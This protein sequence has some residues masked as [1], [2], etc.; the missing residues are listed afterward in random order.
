MQSRQEISQHREEGKTSKNQRTRMTYMKFL[1][2]QS[3]V[4][5]GKS[6]AIL[7][8]FMHCLTGSYKKDPDFSGPRLDCIVMFYF[9]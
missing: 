6:P 1:F 9:L 7:R 3:M 4:I 8:V 2:A 5:A